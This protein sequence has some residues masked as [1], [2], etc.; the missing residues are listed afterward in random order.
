MA[1]VSLSCVAQSAGHTYCNI[2]RAVIYFLWE[3]LLSLGLV[4]QQK[5]QQAW[6]KS[7]IGR[8]VLTV[9]HVVQVNLYQR[10]CRIGS[11]DYRGLYSY[12]NFIHWSKQ[13]V[14]KAEHKNAESPFGNKSLND[15]TPGIIQLRCS[16]C[17]CTFT[18]TLSQPDLMILVPL[19]IQLINCPPQQWK[20]L[21]PTTN[22]SQEVSLLSY[23]K[24]PEGT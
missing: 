8:T 14:T 2:I 16:G 22:T 12:L 13:K 4:F 17:N 10:Q 21:Q 18:V 9:V 1:S 11:S 20:Q 5:L 23:S 24:T 7:Q 6:A 3:T 15:D 19:W